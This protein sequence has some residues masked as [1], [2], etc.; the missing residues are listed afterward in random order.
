MI[1]QKKLVDYAASHSIESSKKHHYVTS[2]LEIGEYTN[3]DI[4]LLIKILRKI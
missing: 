2:S 1:T 3:D 4:I